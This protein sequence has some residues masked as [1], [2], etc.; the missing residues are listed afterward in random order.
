MEKVLQ[1][2]DLKIETFRPPRGQPLKFVSVRAFQA[3]SHLK[4]GIPGEGPCIFRVGA[5]ENP[6]GLED[7]DEIRRYGVENLEKVAT[8][9]CRF[10]PTQADLMESLLLGNADQSLS[11]F[12]R[13][14]ELANTFGPVRDAE[15]PAETTTEAATHT[16]RCRDPSVKP[17]RP[18]AVIFPPMPAADNGLHFLG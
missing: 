6:V 10:I 11:D 7:E 12:E 5:N 13:R 15:G 9:K 17:R 1:C 16:I 8:A 14:V 18:E 4:I 2:S 3:D